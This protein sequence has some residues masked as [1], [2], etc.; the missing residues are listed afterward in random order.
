MYVSTTTILY[1]QVP[2]SV[3]DCM[4]LTAVFN[5][6]INPVIYGAHYLPDF[7]TLG[8]VRR[9]DRWV[10]GG[11]WYSIVMSVLAGR[12]DCSQYSPTQELLSPP[13]GRQ[14]GLD[15]KGPA[16][17]ARLGHGHQRQLWGEHVKQ[18]EVVLGTKIG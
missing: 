7:T 1:L 6:C 4:L 18:F 5:S 12:S 8:R 11:R 16:P 13:H 14:G 15:Q 17:P 10:E 9:G 2:V 3:A